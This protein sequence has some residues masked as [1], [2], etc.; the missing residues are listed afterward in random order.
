MKVAA[1]KGVYRVILFRYISKEILATLFAAV[2]VLSTIFLT[3]QFERYLNDA[4]QGQIDLKTVLQIMGLQIPF[5]WGYLLPVSFFLGVLMALGRLHTDHEMIVMS[6]CG[7]SRTKILAIVLKVACLLAVVVGF[8]MLWLNPKL[9]SNRTQ[10]LHNASATASLDKLIP[11]SFQSIIHGQTLYV[12]GVERHKTQALEIFLANRSFSKKASLYE[13]DVM[14]AMLGAERKIPEKGRFLIFQSGYRHIGMPG[15][16]AYRIIHFEEYGFLISPPEQD[17]QIHKSAIPTSALWKS[18][19]SQGDLQ[20]ELQWRF[21]MPISVLIFAVLAVP[22]SYVN[23]RQGKFGRLF[24]GVLLYIVY[25]NLLFIAKRWLSKDIVSGLL[26]IWWV[27]VFML[28]IAMGLWIS[29]TEIW[30]LWWLRRKRH[31]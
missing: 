25:L 19:L 17:T 14:T 27:H 29:Y 11:G 10:L 13:W 20:A 24:I 3:N 7:V 28:C 4:A 22:L 31:T 2:L 15:T 21:A 18:N 26:G 1:Y 23:P 5:L 8:L 30:R 16:V 12:G 9:E 6:A